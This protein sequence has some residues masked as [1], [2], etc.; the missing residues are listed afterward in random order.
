MFIKLKYEL[1][2]DRMH[3]VILLSSVGWKETRFRC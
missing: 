1:E 2:K 3:Y